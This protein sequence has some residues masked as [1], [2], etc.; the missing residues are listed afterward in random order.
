MIDCV[1]INVENGNFNSKFPICLFTLE[2]SWG[3]FTAFT[4][5]F[6]ATDAVYSNTLNFNLT[7]AN[8]I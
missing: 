7:A 5:V 2:Y 8:G 6:S 1:N 4:F 3:R